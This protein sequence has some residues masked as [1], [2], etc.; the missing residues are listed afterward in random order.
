MPE[1]PTYTS[2]KATEGLHVSDLGVSSEEEAARTFSRIG[3]QLGEVFGG[4]ANQVEEGEQREDAVDFTNKSTDFNIKKEQEATDWINS[5]GSAADFITQKYE[6]DQQAL[7]DGMRTDRGRQAAEMALADQRKAFFSKISND[8]AE[9][10]SAQGQIALETSGNTYAA[11]AFGN[12]AG[13][14]NYLDAWQHNVAFLAGAS[15]VKN[16]GDL[17][18]MIYAGGQHIYGQAADGL[19]RQFQLLQNPTQ[20]DHDKVA[21]ILNSPDYTKYLGSHQAEYIS[22]LDKAQD[23]A[24][25][26]QGEINAQAIP[27]LL[28]AIESGD[29]KRADQVEGL[30]AGDTHGD[31]PEVR[32]AEQRRQLADAVA[33]GNA[34][35]GM[36]N[37]SD[38]AAQNALPA[39][40]AKMR[41]PSTTP[42]QLAP[43]QRQYD[44]ILKAIASRD[45]GIKTKGAQYFLD[46]PQLYG[47]IN[48]KYQAYLATKKTPDDV[49]DPKAFSAYA[50]AAASAER[51]INP[52]N[53]IRI[54]PQELYRDVASKIG[55][56][57][58]DPE[59]A[60]TV[61]TTL[62][63]LQQ[64]TG[65][66][67]NSV[68]HELQ[69]NNVLKSS[70]FAAAQL[71]G[72]PR[73]LPLAQEIVRS[74]VATNDQLTTTSGKSRQAADQLAARSLKTLSA[75]FA[76]TINGQQLMDSY[77]TAI[78]DVMR[79]R[80]PDAVNQ[81]TADKLAQTIVLD[82]FNIRSNLR[83]PKNFDDAD[84][85]DGADNVMA[86]ID[87]H[88][89]IPPK[90][91][92]GLGPEAQRTAY[93][94]DVRDYGHWITSADG[95]GAQLRDQFGA[96]VYEHNAKGQVVPVEVP[97][98]DLERIGRG[99][100]SPLN[101]TERFFT[102]P[103]SLPGKPGPATLPEIP[104]PPQPR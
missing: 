78:S 7:L 79:N 96:P 67:W 71:L 29:M 90:S 94:Q 77:I 45:E 51:T 60:A 83:I 2:P 92:S 4:V 102:N 41:D 73:A 46:N 97:F 56:A 22:K 66:Y 11:Q 81:D 68:A 37:V 85:A 31:H 40:Q 20:E 16:A 104:H 17:Q 8:Q 36:V 103:A 19:I 26:I 86:H 87:T 9:R 84:V 76:E 3:H 59:G 6:P 93:M 74:S 100:R 12:P 21:A 57:T 95:N 101:Q 5:G 15:Q 72:D 35:Q 10:D 30:I 64:L 65:P 39:L 25:N 50:V 70:Q 75:T 98:T 91:F 28:K 80:G 1:L 14:S 89:I 47:T 32:Q 24:D 54:L 43:L 88:N 38:A 99:I 49:G 55:N 48:A 52:Q 33:V 82:R 13:V 18:K 62:S 58:Q 53:P 69:A 23:S 42:D 27:S 61:L 63:N 44:A 34:S